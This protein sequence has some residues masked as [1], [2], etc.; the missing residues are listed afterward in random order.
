MVLKVETSPPGGGEKVDGKLVAELAATVKILD[1]PK[2]FK[3]DSMPFS[4]AIEALKMAQSAAEQQ[5]DFID[6]IDAYPMDAAVALMKAMQE[7]FGMIEQKVVHTPFGDIL[8][9]FITV[10][11]GPG[12]SVNVPWGQLAIPGVDGVFDIRPAQN[13][14]GQKILQMKACVRRK[15]E[16]IVRGVFSRAK[17]IARQHSIY[18]GKGLRYIADNEPQFLDMDPKLTAADD[19]VL[20]LEAEHAYHV[21]VA[22]PICRAE[23]CRRLGIPLRRGILLAG[24]YGTGKTLAAYKTAKLAKQH[25]WTFVYVEKVTEFVEARV[26]AQRFAPA[27]LFVEDI[28]DAA[29]DDAL[30]DSIRNTVDGLD[31]KEQDILMICTT[32]HLDM[33]SSMM[34]GLLRP[35]RVDTII[36]VGFPDG[37]AASRLVKR[38]T[39]DIKLADGFDFEACGEA[40]AGLSAATIRESVERAKLATV[41]R[42][43]NNLS[44][45]DVIFTGNLLRKQ[46][47]SLKKPDD[48]DEPTI[49]SLLREIVSGIDDTESK[50]HIAVSDDIKDLVGKTYLMVRDELPKDIPTFPQDKINTIRDNLKTL[51]KHFGYSF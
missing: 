42:N 13:K 43:G 4:V 14:R 12:E 23:E 7:S 35:G 11:T 49:D 37:E 8:P 15:H 5:I 20:T 18:K 32:N 22:T 16:S 10:M 21:A 17:E 44:H 29:G 30:A 24:P 31:T 33:V 41:A 36:P 3:P 1:G 27:V 6:E 9:K 47:E 48:T 51:G 26:L 19:L 39:R 28:D 38:Y 50:R 25:G 45:E 40:L 34:P 2:L 46:A